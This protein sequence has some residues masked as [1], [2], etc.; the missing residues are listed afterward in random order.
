MGLGVKAIDH[1]DF[2]GIER[3]RRMHLDVFMVERIQEV[4]TG[5]INSDKCNQL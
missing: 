1:K 5:P 2:I 3:D 4:N